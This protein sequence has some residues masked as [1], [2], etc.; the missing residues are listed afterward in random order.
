MAFQMIG[1]CRTMTGELDLDA[2][3]PSL[4]LEF[5]VD[6][7]ILRVKADGPGAVTLTRINAT[8]FR[9]NVTGGDLEFEQDGDTYVCRGVM[10]FVFSLWDTP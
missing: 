5:E 7:A 3:A 8:T 4:L 10:D 9:G 6:D 1:S 2:P